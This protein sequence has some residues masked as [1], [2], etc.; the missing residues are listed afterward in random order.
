MNRFCPHVEVVDDGMMDV[1]ELKVYSRGMADLMAPTCLSCDHTC[2]KCANTRNYEI[3][4]V[5]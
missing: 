5:A 2:E 1:C 3:I 4:D